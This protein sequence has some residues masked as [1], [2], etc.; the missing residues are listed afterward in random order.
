M[1]QKLH[2]GS[3][4]SLPSLRSDPSRVSAQVYYA[5]PIWLLDRLPGT[6]SQRLHASSAV[7]LPL[8]R[9]NPSRASAQVYYSV[10]CFIKFAFRR[11]LGLCPPS[12]RE[13]I[14]R[15]AHDAEGI[16]AQCGCGAVSVSA[17]SR[18]YT[19][20]CHCQMCRDSQPACLGGQA[21]EW[22][23]VSRHSAQLTGEV[24]ITE[25]S[26]LA[27][28]G[29]CAGCASPV[30]MDYEHVEPNTV[31]IYGAKFASTGQAVPSDTDIFWGSR[32]KGAVCNSPKPVDTFDF[33]HSG[34]F[35]DMGAEL[36]GIGPACYALVATA[37]LGVVSGLL[38]SLMVPSV[39]RLSRC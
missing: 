5:F 28:R 14:Q 27:K 15:R 19:V 29:H 12:L 34:F 2:V 11:W 37:A 23:V 18:R 20:T 8:F 4:F 13:V 31:W 36:P 1:S 26:V 24:I 16:V 35:W 6:M 25:S 3:A 7:S 9:S 10:K 30:F 39:S 33:A 22:T 21:P 38:A 17:P 32:I